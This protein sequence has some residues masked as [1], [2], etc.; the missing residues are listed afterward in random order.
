M[1]GPLPL[2]AAALAAGALSCALTLLSLRVFPRLGW[3]APNYRG[4]RLPL[5]TGWA[6]AVAGAAGTLLLWGAVAAPA[7]WVGAPLIAAALGW[8][9]DRLGS[10]EVRGFSAHVRALVRGRLTTGGVKLLGG[11]LL[12]LWAASPAAGWVP[13]GWP[14]APGWRTAGWLLAAGVIALAMNGVN[15]LDLRPGRALKGWALAVVVAVA[16]G[17]R[18]LALVPYAAALLA[19]AYWDLRGRAMQ[20][21]AGANAF[22]AAAG[23]ALAAAPQ[24][25]AHVAALLALA[26]FHLWMERNSLT[27]W[28][29]ERPLLDWLDRLGRP[30]DPQPP[31]RV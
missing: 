28:L 11:G 5:G 2:A 17:A 7:A 22:G 13:A 15:A 8:L 25:A 19:H 23:L 6:P 21:D 4:A 14:A 24:P 3:T 12:A 30:P 10:H 27:V 16:L 29:R 1:T 26:A 9:D 20:G 18:P 31:A